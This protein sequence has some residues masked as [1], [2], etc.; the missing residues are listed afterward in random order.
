MVWPK[1]PFALGEKVNWEVTLCQL[2]PTP[3]PLRS[4]SHPTLPTILL[5]VIVLGWGW[6]LDKALNSVQR[7]S[8]SLSFPSVTRLIHSWRAEGLESVFSIPTRYWQL[9][10]QS[11]RSSN[12][13]VWG[14]RSIFCPGDLLLLGGWSKS[15]YFKWAKEF[16]TLKSKAFLFYTVVF[17]R[18]RNSDLQAWIKKGPEACL[19]HWLTLAEK[20]EI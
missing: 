14:W 5:I 13:I 9:V 2:C 1:A 3:G 10:S 7:P 16:V 15:V 8:E 20:S 19:L 12:S 4:H 18:G 11:F 6:G 17:L